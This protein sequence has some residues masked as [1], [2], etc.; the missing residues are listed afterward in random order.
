MDK[1]RRLRVGLIVGQLSYGGAESQ[2][3]EL[4]RGLGADFEPFVYCLSEKVEPYGRLLRESGIK[5]RILPSHGSFDVLRAAALAKALR[6]DRIV[7]AH[8]FLFIGSAYAYLAT[9]GRSGITLVSS[10]R[11]CKRE[12]NPIRRSIMRRAFRASSAVICNSREMA[13]FA[14]RHYGLPGSLA[15]VVYNGVDTDRFVPARQVSEGRRVGTVGR[16]EEQKNLDMFME[17]AASLVSEE[18]GAV[19][20]IV[21][22]G[23]LRSYYETKASTLGL[24]GSVCFRGTT[25]DIP[26]FLASLNQFW[27][28]S[29]WEGTP[30]VV[31][32][33]MAAGVPVLATSV[34]GVP[35][36]VEDGGCGY[37]FEPGDSEGFSRAALAVLGDSELRSR[38]GERGRE[39]A[40]ERFS[41]AAMV[42]ATEKVYESVLSAGLRRW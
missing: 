24:G 29:K 41:L 20:E 38:L 26:S 33:A 15:T 9:R 5:V 39:L 4:A 30:N 18:A 27:L 37:L 25:A 21:G 11:N 14:G 40:L 31:L 28:T 13:A 1:P 23:S 2:L 17:V 3:F 7:L 19:F 16:I 22:E 36:I 32:E 6:E 10:A 42:S 34:G 8:A 12:P 35:E